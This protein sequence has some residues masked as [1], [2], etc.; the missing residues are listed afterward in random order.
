MMDDSDGETELLRTFSNG[1]G[2]GMEEPR[3]VKPVQQ[4]SSGSQ[5]G[6]APSAASAIVDLALGKYTLGI[7]EKDGPFALPKCGAPVIK[8][9]RGGKDSLRAELA[10]DYRRTTGRVAPQQA[11]TDAL[12]VLE[13]EAQDLEPVELHMRVAAAQGY[14]WYDLGDQTGRAVRIGPDGWQV[15]DRP[16]VLF[17]RSALTA[18]CPEPAR[19]GTNADLFALTN[20]AESDKPLLIAAMVAAFWPSI[21]HPIVAFSGEQ[22][23]GKSTNAMR[24]TGIVD[25]STVPLRKSPRDAESW[26]TAA[27]GSWMVTVDN[28]STINEWFSDALCRASTGDGDVKRRLYS[29]AAL[30][31]FSFRRC[32]MLTGIDLGGLR[33]DLTER[34][35]RI[36][37][38][39]IQAKDRRSEAQMA[40]EYA[41]AHPRTIGALLTLVAQV[42]AALPLVDLT[43]T[44]RLADF[45]RILAAVDQVLGTDGCARYQ[46]Q[47]QS[48]AADSLTANPFTALMMEHATAFTGTAGQLLDLVQSRN[49]EHHRAPAGW[50]KSAR[51]VTTLLRRD[52]PALRSGGWRVTSAENRLGVLTWSLQAPE[53]AG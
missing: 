41:A 49:L 12:Q 50:P 20:A 3:E 35:L 45:H 4:I 34:L 28:I 51:A 53:S 21:A 31:V 25:P 15:V 10:K 6:G 14:H 36:E 37:L 5:T 40:Q 29:D 32:V 23:T 33:G 17:Q 11:L 47:H 19:G 24:V 48:M 18:A 44:M 1:W 9:L 13:G 8:M 16:P 43:E 2:S 27:A 38:D 39:T 42:M 26:I 22:G 52:A 30:S 46:A 7:S